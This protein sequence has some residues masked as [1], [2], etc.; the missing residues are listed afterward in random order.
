M[1]EL[2]PP[3]A[4]AADLIRLAGEQF[5]LLTTFKRDGT[6]V[7]T[8]VWVVADGDRLA[9]TT[10]AATGKVKRIRNNGRALLAP[11]TRSGRRRG[12]DVEVHAEVATGAEGQRVAA[13]VQSK[14][15][16]LGR[17]IELVSGLRRQPAAQRVAVL[18]TTTA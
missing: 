17:I 7:P 3:A 1:T 10:I 18:L 8:P 14:Y 2:P 6:A 15:G 11:C 13:L 5:V 12:P 16:L 9:V 4:T